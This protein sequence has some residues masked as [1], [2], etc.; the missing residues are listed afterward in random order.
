MSF[1]TIVIDTGLSNIKNILNVCKVLNINFDT[2]QN[3]NNFKNTKSII[4][5]GVGS[6]IEGM[7][8]L[9]KLDLDGKIIDFANSKRPI[10]GICLGM[11]LLMNESEEFGYTKG[12]SLI[13]G[14]VEKFNKNKVPNIPHIGWNKVDFVNNANKILFYKNTNSSFFY[15]I[16]SFY[17]NLN[18]NYSYSTQTKFGDTLFCSSLKVDNIFVTQF[19]P[20]KS[21]SNG[22]RVI[23]NF[24]KE[25][26]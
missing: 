6:F 21:G 19:H 20:E 15:F 23:D 10:L 18:K 24:F 22:I 12:L 7:R 3:I 4:L 13:D 14:K 2:T 9:K 5:P 11:Q 1:D 26:L 8:R 17:V 25:I 16:H